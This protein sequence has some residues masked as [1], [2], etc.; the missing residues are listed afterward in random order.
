MNELWQLYDEQG[1]VLTLS[2]SKDEIHKKGLLHGAAHVWIWRVR[3]NNL[4]VLLQKRAGDKH[5]WPSLYDIS[6]AGHIDV[7]EDPITTALRETSEEIGI[8]INDKDLNLILVDRRILLAP[9][10]AIE[11]EFCW[12]YTLRMDEHE[13]FTLEKSEVSS[14]RWK[15]FNE[16]K[17]E[18]FR[19]NQD[20][21]VPQGLNY[22]KILISA[23]EG[24]EKK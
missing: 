12:V 22:F 20:Q 10:G 21:Y 13:K 7:G 23:I 2:A 19:D 11:N 4:E 14:L 18:I 17:E 9:S 5:T 6:A 8:K 15:D 1:R 24:G 16:F 3:D